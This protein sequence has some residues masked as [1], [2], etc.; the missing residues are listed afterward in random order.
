MVQNGP[1]NVLDRSTTNSPSRGPAIHTSFVGLFVF[2]IRKSM[3]KRKMF[4][5]PEFDTAPIRSLLL[6]AKAKRGELLNKF[7]FC[8]QASDNK[9]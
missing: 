4:V 6:W 3:T 1:A 2:S 9:I 5:K 7:G 8:V